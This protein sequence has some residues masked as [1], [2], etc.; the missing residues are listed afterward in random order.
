MIAD[1]LPSPLRRAVS[2]YTGVV[3]TLEEC[4]H[5]PTEPPLHRVACELGRG[6]ALLGTDLDHLSGIG[7]AGFT[8]ADAAAAAVG[9]A[10][11][12][13]SASYVPWE[14]IVVATAS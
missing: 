6:P 3:R 10:L 9:E 13:Y 14:R 11:E 5:L 1:A 4:L 12:R 7:G 2:P 8:R